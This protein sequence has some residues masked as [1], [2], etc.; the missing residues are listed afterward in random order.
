[1]LDGLGIMCGPCRLRTS[2]RSGSWRPFHWAS[3]ALALWFVPSSALGQAESAVETTRQ[4]FR[5]AGQWDWYDAENDQVRPLPMPGERASE[6][7]REQEP[8]SPNSFKESPAESREQVRS[9]EPGTV[10]ALVNLFAWIMI[11]SLLVGFLVVIVAAIWR[12]GFAKKKPSETAEQ[13]ETESG[14]YVAEMPFFLDRPESEWLR[15]ARNHYEQGNYRQAMIYVYAHMLNVLDEHRWL[16]LA[17]G[18]T[19]RQFLKELRASA[20]ERQL[21]SSMGDY[22]YLAMMRFEK[23]FFGSHAL[24]RDELDAIWKGLDRFLQTAAGERG[25]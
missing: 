10:S 21:N 12:S 22:F 16:Q 24:T 5:N 3:C 13:D 15:T 1:M 11:V 20:T 9:T 4:A 23:A 2:T 19:N 7:R 18:K 6:S 8:G 17:R 14:E 25:Q